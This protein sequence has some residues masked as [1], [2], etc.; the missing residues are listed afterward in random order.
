VRFYFLFGVVNRRVGS[1]EDIDPGYCMEFRGKNADHFWIGLL[2]AT[3]LS[4]LFW[5]ALAFLII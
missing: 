4:M 2:N 5:I 1:Y 3:A